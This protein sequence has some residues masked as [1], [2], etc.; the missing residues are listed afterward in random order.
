LFKERQHSQKKTLHNYGGAIA[1]PD[2]QAGWSDCLDIFFFPHKLRLVKKGLRTKATEKQS[3]F[4]LIFSNL[5][6][7]H[8]AFSCT[9]CNVVL[10]GK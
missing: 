6:Y 7:R 3:R 4:L 9:E 10:K 2:F 5:P 8:S 1:P